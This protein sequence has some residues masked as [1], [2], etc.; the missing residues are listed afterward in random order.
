MTLSQALAICHIHSPKR[1]KEI[2]VLRDRGVIIASFV[3]FALHGMTHEDNQMI[4]VSLLT[5]LPAASF[6]SLGDKQKLFQNQPR[7]MDTV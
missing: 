1:S 2:K 6:L 4:I 7:F 3:T 5:S